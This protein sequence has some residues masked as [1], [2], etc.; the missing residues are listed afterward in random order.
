M[1]TTR[2]MKAAIRR[3]NGHQVIVLP[4]D[5]HFDGDEVMVRQD[6]ETGEV[7]VIS[8]LAN[9][10]PFEQFLAWRDANPIPDEEW[11]PFEEAMRERR[12]L[13]I[14]P[15]DKALINLFQDES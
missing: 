9:P 10:S 13:D 15:D 7:T 2:T 11:A 8:A 5:I 3:E 4:D 6:T 1:A 14:P 12:R